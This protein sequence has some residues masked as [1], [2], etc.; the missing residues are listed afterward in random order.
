[1]AQQQL[2]NTHQFSFSPDSDGN[3]QARVDGNLK[4]A[5]FIT[6][7][8]FQSKIYVD[9]RD[10]FTEE[11]TQKTKP[12]KR[13]VSLIV[14]DWKELCKYSEMI[15]GSL[16]NL[17][18]NKNVANYPKEFEVRVNEQI[19]LIVGL[20]KKFGSQALVPVVKICKTTTDGSKKPQAVVISAYAWQLV[21][22]V[23][24]EQIDSII[25]AAEANAKLAATRR[26]Q[27]WQNEET[28]I[29]QS[30][31]DLPSECVKYSSN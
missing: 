15:R 8:T 26:Q 7:K 14:S 10:Y 1:M 11:A 17:H 20:H 16:I 24:R 6:V 31:L 18:N 19:T 25:E 29:F 3:Q 28:Q 12:T 21:T 13:G 22:K 4:S 27:D 23:N 9:F 30:F 5:L 2:V